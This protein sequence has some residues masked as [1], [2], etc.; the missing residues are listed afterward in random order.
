MFIPCSLHRFL[1]AIAQRLS[2]ASTEGS[3]AVVSESGVATQEVK[4]ELAAGQAVPQRLAACCGDPSS[5]ETNR[6][7]E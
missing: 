4:G 3:T 6:A 5:G 2:N 1:D 7:A